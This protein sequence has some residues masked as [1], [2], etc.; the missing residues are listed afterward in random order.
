MDALC[1]R[2]RRAIDDRE[3]AERRLARL[4]NRRA[5]VR[6]GTRTP[7]GDGDVRLAE[8][9]ARYVAEL[10]QGTRDANIAV[11]KRLDLQPSQV[12]DAIHR[13]RFRGCCRP[14][15]RKARLAVR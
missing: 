2:A 10:Q 3:R 12:R 4:E 8:I 14:P 1:E 9:A 15:T 11:A 6:N 5:Q 7:R 13:A